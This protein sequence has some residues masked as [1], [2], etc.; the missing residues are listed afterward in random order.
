MSFDSLNHVLAALKQQSSPE[1]Q[2]YHRL[3]EIWQAVVEPSV[4][5]QTRPLYVTRQVL[6]VATSSSVW[7]QT[8][9]LQRYALLK[10]LN[11]QLG[12][13]L[14]DIRFSTAHWHK[15]AHGSKAIAPS[16][17]GHPSRAKH[18]PTRLH[19]GKTPQEA[20]ERWSKVIQERSPLPTCPRCQCPTPEGE[21]Q[22]WG[23]CYHCITKQWQ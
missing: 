22:R 10:K 2:Q 8:L 7:A 11:V 20:L 12:E 4:A 1:L 15:R 18:V 13:P 17:E 16:L 5:L 14:V 3:L 19:P 9:S 21:L 23:L 6:S